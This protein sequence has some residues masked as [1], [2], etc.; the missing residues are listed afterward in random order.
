M[1]DY[2]GDNFQDNYLNLPQTFI[3]ENIGFI[4]Q[5]AL[6]FDD[7][8]IN[9]IKYGKQDASEE[10]VKRVCKEIGLDEFID[11]MK[12]TIQKSKSMLYLNVLEFQFSLNRRIF[13][14]LE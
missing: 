3:R 7:T 10:E 8:I 11:K 4:L 1:Q 2:Q 13:Y 14:E 12:E 9:N 5:D 6:L